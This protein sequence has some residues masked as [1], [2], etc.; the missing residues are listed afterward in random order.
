M[1]IDMIGCSFGRLTVIGIGPRL[2]SGLDRKGLRRKKTSLLVR[3]ECGN[4]KHVFAGSLRNGSTVSCGC[5]IRELRKTLPRL[6]ARTTCHNHLHPLYS[7]WWSM[8]VRCYNPKNKRWSRYGGRGIEVCERWNVFENFVEDMPERPYGY[9]ID[10]IDNDGNYEPGNCRW[11]DAKMQG[12]NSS[13][14]RIIEYK[15]DRLSITQ[16]AEKYHMKVATLWA[17]LKKGMSIA[18]ALETPLRGKCF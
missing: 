7:V 13:T 1:L 3:C 14:T 4:E 17:R 8:H 16:F 18:E 10:R 11:A 2:F 5:Y 9:S 15:G 12:N 6:G